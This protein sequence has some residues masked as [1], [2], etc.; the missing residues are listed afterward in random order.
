[1]EVAREDAAV[2]DVAAAV[3]VG[4]AD[5]TG[6]GEFECVVDFG[7]VETL[8]ELLLKRPRVVARVVRHLLRVV[9]ERGLVVGSSETRGSGGGGEGERC[10]MLPRRS[11]D[12][13]VGKTE[14]KAGSSRGVGA[15]EMREGFFLR[16][17]GDLGAVGEVGTASL[18]DA[19]FRRLWLERSERDMIFR[20]GGMRATS[21]WMLLASS[22]IPSPPGSGLLPAAR[23]VSH[24]KIVESAATVT[25]RAV[26][27][28]PSAGMYTAS[29]M[30]SVCP[31]SLAMS[32]PL[33]V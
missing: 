1:V 20:K 23:T 19:G 3:V 29:V 15:V 28:V 30:P 26:L 6:V 24:M 14:R 21:F 4:V 12:G 17:W 27:Q 5:R 2:E 22:T 13:E 31:Q 7:F 32:D 10:R 8:S 18:S 25:R 16:R 11:D 9:W 33:S